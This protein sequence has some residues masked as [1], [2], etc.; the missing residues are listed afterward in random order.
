MIVDSPKDRVNGT[1][2][3]RHTTKAGFP[4]VTT[5]YDRS[6]TTP[7]TVIGDHY[8]ALVDMGDSAEDGLRIIRNNLVSGST[9]VLAESGPSGT[10]TDAHTI[11]VRD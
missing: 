11:N 1:T 7:L 9:Q 8:Y 5:G 3:L 2:V 4:A 10:I 6:D